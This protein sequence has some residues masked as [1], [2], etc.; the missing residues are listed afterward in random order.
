M[1]KHTKKILAS[2]FLIYLALLGKCFFF[3]NEITN[4][5]LKKI[6]KILKENDNIYYL[7][8]VNEKKLPV[9]TF[10]SQ[11]KINS[12]NFTLGNNSMSSP[13]VS[14]T[15]LYINV[16]I[17]NPKTRGMKIYSS[18][19]FYS[20][21]VLTPN[22]VGTNGGNMGISLMATVS[23]VRSNKSNRVEHNSYSSY[24]LT[25]FEPFSSSTPFSFNPHLV[26]NYFYTENSGGTDPGGDPEGPPIPVGDGIGFLIL[27]VLSYKRL[28]SYHLFFKKED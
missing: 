18:E 15:R 8:H 14:Y 2:F 5:S 13:I 27:L 19:T 16:N 4:D 12:S 1:N 26:D 7:S 25:F 9:A 24:S 10:S 6:L 17:N 28:K 3:S 22:P 23:S 11:K 20:R 21:N